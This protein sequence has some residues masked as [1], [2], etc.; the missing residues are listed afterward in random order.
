MTEV[1]SFDT[2]SPGVVRLAGP[3]TFTTCTG[4]YR[5]ME[6]RLQRG[7]AIDMLD[8]D[9]VTRV[10]SAGLA[11]LLEW[12]ARRVAE[13]GRLRMENAPPGLIQLAR[14]SNAVDLLEVTGKEAPG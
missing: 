2:E 9:A 8:L 3:L 13:G 11:L 7:E 1:I 5:K 4:L 14:L 6:R 10:D 12:Q